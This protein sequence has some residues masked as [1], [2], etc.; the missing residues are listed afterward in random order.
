MRANRIIILLFLV[1]LI[2]T[3]CIESFS[4]SLDEYQELLVIEGLITDREGVHK[5]TVS[6]SSIYNA[7]YLDYESG[8]TVNV[9]DDKGNVFNMTEKSP[10]IYSSFIEQQYLDEGTQYRVEVTTADGNKYQSTY[11][12]LLHNPPVDSIYDEVKLIEQ[13]DPI[14]GT[15]AGLQFYVDL[16]ATNYEAEGYRWELFE[17]W[18]YWSR[19]YAKDYYDG[20]IHRVRPEFASDSVKYCW[21]PPQKINEIFTYSTTQS[22]SKKVK[23]IP[24]TY[25]SNQSNRLEHS[26]CL[27]VKQYSMSEAAFAY[28]NKLQIQANETGGLYETQPSRVIGNLYNVDDPDEIVLGYFSASGVTEK[29]YFTRLPYTYDTYDLFVDQICEPAGYTMGELLEKLRHIHPSSYPV[30]LYTPFYSTDDPVDWVEQGCVNCMLR[31]GD[32]LRPDYWRY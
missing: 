25:V 2:L 26:Y 31:G 6:R 3:G 15:I 4:P 27:L 18:E 1:L 17:E 21:M 16:D 8:C 20:E 12:R 14:L 13:D 32:T 23:K 24:L 28:W 7:P 22:T 5:V 9:F 10:G 11:E 29:R 19:Y 30:Y